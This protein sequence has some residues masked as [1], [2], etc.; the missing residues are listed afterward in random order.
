M[1]NSTT[2]EKSHLDTIYLKQHY[3]YKGIFKHYVIFVNI[4]DEYS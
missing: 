1:N 4:D 2:K 3:I